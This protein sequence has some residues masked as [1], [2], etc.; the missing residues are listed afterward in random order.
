[1]KKFCLIQVFDSRFHL[2]HISPKNYHLFEEFRSDPANARLYVISNRY[3][4]VKMVCDG[5]EV[6]E[7]KVFKTTILILKVFR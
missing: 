3:T 2:D 7:I 4:E 1:M 5:N 6:T